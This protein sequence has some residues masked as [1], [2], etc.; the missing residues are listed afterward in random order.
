MRGSSLTDIADELCLS[1]KTV[2]TH[3]SHILAKMGLAG[4]VDLVRYAI[5]HNLLDPARE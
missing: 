1:I 3:K 5:E 4:Q 2:S